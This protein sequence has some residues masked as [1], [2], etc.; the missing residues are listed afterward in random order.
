M[1]NKLFFAPNRILSYLLLAVVLFTECSSSGKEV[2]KPSP[3]KQPEQSEWKLN[4]AKSDDFNEW[5]PSKWKKELWYKTSSDFAFNPANVSVRNGNL[6]IAIKKET[7]EGKNYTAGAII[8]EFKAGANT[9]IEI[10]AK[11]PDYNTHVTSA[12]WLAN[13][14]VPENS[15]N[16]E[17]DIMETYLNKNTNHNRFT[18]GMHYWW[19]TPKPVWADT[20]TTTNDQSL[21]WLDHS[22]N[23]QLSNQYHIWTIERYDN[24]IKFYFDNQ[25]YWTN[26]IT[27]H[28]KKGYFDSY[29]PA[30]YR[31]NFNEQERSIIFSV[32]GHA[33]VP[34]EAYLP[35]EFL[36]DY[37]RVYDRN[38]GK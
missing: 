5:T 12:L 28:D 34:A 19:R 17:I 14:P 3:P 6:V 23:E 22:I 20:I 31:K 21:G 7:L 30:E 4:A 2:D 9:R 37:V 16:L 35:A 1:N 11:L 33:G 36:I 32:E 38:M 24:K 8:S 15:P 18:S 13:S 29:I 27:A 26:D 25:L 10:R